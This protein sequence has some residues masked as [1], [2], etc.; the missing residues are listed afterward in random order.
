[1]DGM[2]L[3]NLETA[4]RP[5]QIHPFKPVKKSF[6]LTTLPPLIHT[7][8]VTDAD[9]AADDYFGYSVSQS[10]NILPSANLPIRGG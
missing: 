10:G 1:M 8:K 4:Y 7:V 5:I 6:V 3:A 2:E 9:G